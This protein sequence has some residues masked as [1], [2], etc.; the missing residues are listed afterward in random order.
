MELNGKE[1]DE[2]YLYVRYT[3]SIKTR[4]GDYEVK[5]YDYGYVRVLYPPLIARITG[6]ITAIKGNG[7]VTLDASSSYDPNAMVSNS[8]AL[9]FIWYCQRLPD[10]VTEQGPS[11]CYGPRPGKLSSTE[12]MIAV[13]VDRMDANHTYLF[14]LVVSKDR[15]VSRAFHTL[16]VNPPYVISLR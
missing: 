9:T 15:R 4:S 1:L 5:T 2:S 14:E 16:T 13:D 11:D 7:S 8:S 10:N 12:P 3:A 6:S